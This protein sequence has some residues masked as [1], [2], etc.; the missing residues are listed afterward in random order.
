MPTMKP[1]E[2]LPQVRLSEESDGS[3]NRLLNEDC[4]VNQPTYERQYRKQRLLNIFLIINLVLISSYTLYLHVH[5]RRDAVPL[6]A[7]PFGYV[8]VGTY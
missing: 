2:A 4:L 5:G 8:P 6:G 3:Q 1:Y 7:D